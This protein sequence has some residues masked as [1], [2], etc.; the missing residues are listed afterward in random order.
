[1]F[2]L[3]RISG[4][5]VQMNSVLGKSYTFIDDTV[6]P[7]EFERSMELFDDNRD[8]IY[9]FVGDEG[10]NIQPLFRGQGAYIMTGSGKTFSNVS[11]ISRV[12]T[13]AANERP[14]WVG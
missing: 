1:M 7:K 12:P 10:G 2:V 6:D 13:P 8:K 14:D 5:G 3:R 4:Q 11:P 9:A